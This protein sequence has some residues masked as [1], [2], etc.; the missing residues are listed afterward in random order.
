MFAIA[1]PSL[2]ALIGFVGTTLLPEEVN[3]AMLM[4][5]IPGIE[6]LGSVGQ[7]EARAIKLIKNA[8]S[9]RAAARELGQITNKTGRAF[10]EFARRRLFPNFD[11]KEVQFGRRVLD[12]IWRNWYI[13]LKTGK[14]LRGRELEQLKEFAAAA[15]RDGYGLAYVFLV[16]PARSATRKILEAGGRVLYLFD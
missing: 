12:L 11:A 16:K 10:E 9:E 4:S 14:S 7:A 15:K 8:A 1:H 2:L 3:N 13:E 6:E 5:G